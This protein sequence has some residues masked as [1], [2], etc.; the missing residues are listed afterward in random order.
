MQ[1]KRLLCPL[2]ILGG[3]FLAAGLRG[4][5]IGIEFTGYVR[6]EKGL[7]LALRNPASGYSRWV[8]IGQ[9]FE[10]YKVSRL[11][12]KTEVLVLTKGGVEFSLPL[13]RAKIKQA[14]MEIPPEMKR[15][16]MNNLRQ[17]AAA[18]NQHFL[19]QEVTR[20]TYDDLV[21]RTKYVKEINPVDGE[22]YR[23]IVFEQGKKF[24]VQTSQG[25]IVSYTP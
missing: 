5:E 1:L 3:I 19:E 24:Q 20:A 23:G 16:I 7:A 14:D 2:L 4:A 21:G 17:L 10:D 11:N 8:A 15:K 9:E 18:A 6:D 25:Y 13:V 22:D 12:E